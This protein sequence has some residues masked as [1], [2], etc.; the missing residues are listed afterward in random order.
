MLNI[1]K[2]QQEL[3]ER[4]LARARL[5]HQA[6]ALAA[7][8]VEVQIGEHRRGVRGIF[9]GETDVLEVDVAGFDL[10]RRCVRHV[11]DETRFVEDAGHFGG[12]AEDLVQ[13][14]EHGIDH[15]EAHGEVVGVSEHHHERA[16]ADA[17]P[18]VAARGEDRD[19]GHD[20]H[21]ERRGHDAALD[22]SAHAAGIGAHGFEGGIGEEGALVVFAAVGFHGEDVRNRVGKYA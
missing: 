1:G 19:D 4:G 17:E 16:G 22:G 18:R 13:A 10:E 5:A 3:R 21:D 6:N 8:N 14:R 15:V 2:A 7:R 12:V 9:V 20:D 11:G